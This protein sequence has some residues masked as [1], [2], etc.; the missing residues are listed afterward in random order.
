MI[1]CRWHVVGSRAGAGVS[2]STCLV[3]LNTPSLV[4]EF[5]SGLEKKIN[6]G[7]Q[8][9]PSPS[10]F[11]NIVKTHENM[12]I[13]EFPFG[14]R[15]RL[16][17]RKDNDSIMKPWRRNPKIMPHRASLVTLVLILT[18]AIAQ[19]Q[20]K[21][22]WSDEF[23]GPDIDSSK[24]THEVNAWGGGNNELQYYTDRPENSFIENGML[25]IRAIR[26]TF[27][28]PEGTRQYTSAR[29]VTAEKGDWR[30]GRFEA[31]AKMP[32]G[33]G[34]WPAI[35]ML[36]TDWEYGG[37]AASG[38][39][40]IMEYRGNEPNII[41][42]TIHYGGPWPANTYTG[43]LYVG[44]DFSH[45]FH[46]FSLEWEEMEMRWYVDDIHY[47]TQTSWFTTEAPFPAPFDQRF[48]LILNL[49][50]GGNFLPNPPPNPD[51]FPQDLIVD[52]VRVYQRIS[53]PYFG[54]P[55]QLPARIQAEHYNLGGNGIA[56]ND[57]TSA[58]LGSGFRE[59]ESVDIQ[60]N[61]DVGGGFNVGWVEPGEWLDYTVE[62][63]ASGLWQIDIRTASNNNGG[64]LAIVA[65]GEEGTELDR[66]QVTLPHTNG[67]Q[68]WTTVTSPSIQLPEGVFMLRAEII[69][70]EFNINWLETIPIDQNGGGEYW[71]TY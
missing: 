41:H 27:T 51:Y 66:V 67:W 19:P 48:H 40:D 62:T 58:Q 46:V 17:L 31:R 32:L 49:A 33:Q 63:T 44:P 35:W 11:R 23:E 15:E 16:T 2:L 22:V 24:W 3:N 29:M 8:N 6:R 64:V 45:D 4:N 25:H 9:L 54:E 7:S 12:G 39:I 59:T 68:N 71:M 65:R 28:G 30:Y 1:W 36:P 43:D 53:E 37:W 21:L 47:A 61:S 42:G 70:G 50:V 34:L 10:I 57:L 20:W 56:Y 5:W 38:E 18:P 13:M 26:E 14:L 69:S 52:W 55:F 60:E